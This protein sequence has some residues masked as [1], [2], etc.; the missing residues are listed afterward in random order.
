MPSVLSTAR[1]RY[2]KLRAW[3][4][5]LS[6]VFHDNCNTA[7]KYVEKN[8]NPAVFP[9]NKLQ[10]F[11]CRE[12]P[13]K[14]YF[15][16]FEQSNEKEITNE[17]M[18]DS[19]SKIID[20]GNHSH[21]LDNPIF[22]AIG[23]DNLISVN[24]Q[25]SDETRVR[26]FI[27]RQF[28]GIGT[29]PK[30]VQATFCASAA[31]ILAE[32]IVP[33]SVW[34]ELGPKICNEMG[35]SQKIVSKYKYLTAVTARRFGKTRFISMTVVNYALS[36]PGSTIIIF[37][38]SQDASDLLRQDVEN[39]ISEAGEIEFAGIMYKLADLKGRGHKKMK[40]RSPYNM[41]KFSTIYFKPGLH[42]HNMDKQ[43]CLLLIFPNRKKEQSRKVCIFI[44]SLYLGKSGFVS[45]P[46]SGLKY[47]KIG[48]EFRDFLPIGIIKCTSLSVGL[49]ARSRFFS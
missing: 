28:S 33:P 8:V 47:C 48:S 18:K 20:S 15:A 23:D 5:V 29:I 16:L 42:K 45:R 30:K 31:M 17:W 9:S 25:A 32:N 40:L 24:E 22:R 12:A 14:P 41:D 26:E 38:T 43:V 35:W 44:I 39:M 4:K 7:R 6:P 3:N 37:S 21:L 49:V 10:L 11:S 46:I 27:S 13:T 19:V 34:R 1:L 36:K 2:N